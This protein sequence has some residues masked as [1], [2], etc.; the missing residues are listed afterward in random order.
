MNENGGPKNN[1]KCS[2]AWMNTG[3]QCKMYS[4]NNAKYGKKIMQ[5]VVEN[6]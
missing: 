4:K 3:N 1:A 5:N 6:E 2:Q